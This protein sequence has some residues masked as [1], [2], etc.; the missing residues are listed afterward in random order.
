MLLTRSPLS[1]EASPE[2]PFDLHVLSTPPAFVL[3]Q[4]QT[5]R[6]KTQPPT[7]PRRSQQTI[8]TKK[9]HNPGT[10]RNHTR[11]GVRAQSPTTP[12]RPTATPPKRAAQRQTHS[13]HQL[14]SRHTVEFSNNR[15]TPAPSLAGGPRGLILRPAHPADRSQGA[16]SAW[17]VI[18]G[19]PPTGP[20]TAWCPFLPFGGLVDITRGRAVEA[21]PRCG[22]AGHTRCRAPAA[23]TSV[24]R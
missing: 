18:V 13:W 7:N 11:T 5:L 10:T 17:V 20:S 9:Q 6:Q 15:P 24:P 21:N 14:L 16:L 2:A 22:D 12:S 1:P 4:N 3:S 8:N 19:W 23:G